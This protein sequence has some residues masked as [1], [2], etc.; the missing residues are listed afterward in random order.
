MNREGTFVYACPGG[1]PDTEVVPVYAVEISNPQIGDLLRHAWQ[2]SK[3][4]QLLE[5]I[6]AK[7]DELL[8]RTAPGASVVEEI[9]RRVN[10]A[11]DKIGR[12]P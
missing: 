11:L 7:L 1:P 3:D 9:R 2:K 10:D 4:T 5:E 6:N 12:K 8:R